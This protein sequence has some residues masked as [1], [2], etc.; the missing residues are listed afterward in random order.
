MSLGSRIKE[1]RKDHKLTGEKFGAMIGGV[2][3]V[4]LYKYESDKNTPG[5]NLLRK[6]CSQFGGK[7]SLVAYWRRGEVHQKRY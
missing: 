2:H 4:T 3:Q 5:A 7:R 6:I 1:V